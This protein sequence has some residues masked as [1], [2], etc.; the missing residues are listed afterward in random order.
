[1][2]EKTKDKV[3]DYLFE[4]DFGDDECQEELRE[5]KMTNLKPKNREKLEKWLMKLVKYN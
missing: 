3:V 5:A 4:Q 1:M 2:D